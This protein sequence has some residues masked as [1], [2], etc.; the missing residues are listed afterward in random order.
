MRPRRI[1]HVRP[2]PIEPTHPDESHE[3]SRQNQSTTWM[4]RTST[5]ST[6]DH[7]RGR[8]PNRAMERVQE[9]KQHE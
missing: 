2:V 5:S 7:E 1:Q 6:K 4:D 8:I 9:T 3:K